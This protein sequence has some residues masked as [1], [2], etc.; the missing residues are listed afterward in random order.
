MLCWLF[1]SSFDIYKGQVRVTESM[2]QSDSDRSEV[3]NRQG[4][5]FTAWEQ[6]SASQWLSLSL[7]NHWD[8]NTWVRFDLFLARGARW[9][10]THRILTLL[11]ETEEEN[12]GQNIGREVLRK[13][14]IW[15]PL[16]RFFDILILF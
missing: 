7:S 9:T 5:D 6:L 2:G 10:Q 13:R 15:H 16:H 11:R 12:E 3:Q 14:R 4:N 1:L 8:Y